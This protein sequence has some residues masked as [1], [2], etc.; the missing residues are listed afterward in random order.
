MGQQNSCYQFL[1]KLFQYQLCEVAVPG[2][3]SLLKTNWWVRRLNSLRG[4]TLLHFE[5][6]FFTCWVACQFFDIVLKGLKCENRGT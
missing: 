5:F 1:Y 2:N 4:Q 3:D 6:I